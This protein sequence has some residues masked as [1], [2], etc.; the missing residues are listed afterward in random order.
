MFAVMMNNITIV[1]CIT[2]ILLHESLSY[3]HPSTD[4]LAPK[5]LL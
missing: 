4:Q 2:G 3:C 5:A 1:Y